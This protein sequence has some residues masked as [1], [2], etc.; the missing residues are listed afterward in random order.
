MLGMNVE[1]KTRCHDL[2][3]VARLASSLGARYEGRLE[4]Q[5]TYFRVGEARLKLRELSHHSPDGSVSASAELIRYERPDESGPRVSV[6]ERTPVEDA[7]AA[8]AQLQAMH[9]V[10]GCVRK[11]RSL[12]I[13]D[14]TRI[15]LDEVDGLGAFV[16]LETVS[17]GEPGTT[18]QHEH[19][20][21]WSALGLDPK[22]PSPARTSTCSSPARR[23]G[24][25]P[26]RNRVSPLSELVAD[27]ARGLVYG[28]R[29]C[30]HDDTGRI[31]RR[32]NGKRWIACRLEFK[33]WQ[34]ARLLQPGRF[35]ELF[36]LDEATAFAAGHRPCALC[37]WED[38]VRFR[39]L[40]EELHPSQ[41]GADAID[42]QLHSERVEPGSRGQLHHRAQLD[43]LPD[44]AFV[45]RD[46]APWLV[47]GPQ[48][49]RWTPA[50]YV[51]ARPR[52]SGEAALITPPSLVAI[53][54]T[55]WTGVVPLLDSSAR[56]QTPTI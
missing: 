14:S 4:Q 53:L 24:G 36:F 20:R 2:E 13:L 22:R 46:D 15:H 19:D 12:W 5:D 51:D 41:V 30:L 40:W 32:Y 42:Q 50:G 7:Q 10:R 26:L 31:R 43:N 48:L 16:E 33:G 29:G 17:E 54:A 3:A 21:V 39:R 27:P 34:R 18:E 47:V 44:G 35:T 28:N 45:L 1:S 49:M 56:S 55:G 37:R 9:G 8:S 6:Y 11:Q 52:K 23:K 38:Y 25:M